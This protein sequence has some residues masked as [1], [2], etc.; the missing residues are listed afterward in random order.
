MKINPRSLTIRFTIPYV[1]TLAIIV[2]L[3]IANGFWQSS[4][5]LNQQLDGTLQADTD[6]LI[7]TYELGGLERVTELL[8]NR[9]K[10]RPQDDVVYL[11]TDQNYKTILGNIQVWP[12]NFPK[13]AKL[14]EVDRGENYEFGKDIRYL[15]TEFANGFHLLVGRETIQLEILE[16][17]A[18]VT[19]SWF[20]AFIIFLGLAGGFF[21][22]RKL[23]NKLSTITSHCEQ[24]RQ[25]DLFIR[26]PAKDKGDEI[27]DMSKT[28]NEMLDQVQSLMQD[29]QH[30]T[31]NIAHDLR[32][33]LTRVHNQLELLGAELENETHQAK[34]YQ[35]I[36]DLNDLLATF[37]AMLRISQLESRSVE[38]NF[39]PVNLAEIIQD[40]VELYEPLADEK[41]QEITLSQSDQLWIEGDRNL[42][43]QMIGNILE[44]AI[45]Y[46]QPKSVHTVEAQRFGDRCIIEIRDQ[47]PGIPISE[48]PN[49]TKRFYR[50]DKSRHQRGNG[51]GLSLVKA[52]ANLH[53]GTVEFSNQSGLCVKLTFPFSGQSS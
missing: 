41:E 19:S 14:L 18:T 12:E 6:A 37:N 13:K 28:L 2:V 36:E 10:K 42:I 15:H 39:T 35:A 8:E 24:I 5:L 25:G 52:V 9:L 31:D 46:T 50:L 3:F 38:S 44:N 48:L 23:N 20:I 53:H 16:D 47:G 33:P 21:L 30:I 40:C 7:E 27:N 4:R 26:F 49:I 22:H 1:V 34:A 29:I 32:T 51:L 17:Q 11:L 43:F 45:K